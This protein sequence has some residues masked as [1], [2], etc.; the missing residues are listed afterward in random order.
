MVTYVSFN[1]I[2]MLILL[3]WRFCYVLGVEFVYVSRNAIF[4]QAYD[5]L[6][7][8]YFVVVGALPLSVLFLALER[9]FA[10][11]LGA[12]FSSRMKS[13]IFMINLIGS[14]GNNFVVYGLLLIM[15]G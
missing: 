10:I 4:L 15:E 12:K 7:K 14:P 8:A 6:L 13:I 9:C 1:A 2:G 11:Q 5:C 3:C